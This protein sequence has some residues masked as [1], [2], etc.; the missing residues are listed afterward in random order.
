MQWRRKLPESGIRF[1]G[2]CSKVLSRFQ[3]PTVQLIREPYIVNAIVASMWCYINVTIILF[4]TKKKKKNL[5]CVNSSRFDQNVFELYYNN[6]CS[7][8]VNKWIRIWV[9][10]NVNKYVSMQ[11]LFFFKKKS[12]IILKISNY[13]LVVNI[14]NIPI[15][16]IKYY[17]F[18]KDQNNT[19]NFQLY[20]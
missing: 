7:K 8:V 13:F 19:F 20:T 15:T 3:K 4:I 18:E 5:C 11:C 14:I 1:L 12:S 17:W 16:N 9:M 2:Y 10:F 6:I